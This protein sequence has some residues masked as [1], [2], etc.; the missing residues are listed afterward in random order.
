MVFTASSL[1]LNK[2]YDIIV[3]LERHFYLIIRE[4]ADDD[5]YVQLTASPS[6]DVK[7]LSR[8]S[9][10]KVSAI[11]VFNFYDMSAHGGAKGL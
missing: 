2:T 11:I 7:M 10:L 8:N 6:A 3:L 1:Q 9:S 5:L 4:S